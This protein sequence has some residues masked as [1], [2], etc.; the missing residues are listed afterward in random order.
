MLTRRNFVCS[1]AILLFVCAQLP[2]M[3]WAQAKSDAA[4]SKDQ[5]TFEVYQDT[6]KE[7]RWRLVSGEGKDREV[8]ATGGQGYKVKPK[9]PTGKWLPL[10]ARVTKPRRSATA[11]SNRSRKGRPKRQLRKSKPTNRDAVRFQHFRSPKP[12]AENRGVCCAS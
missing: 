4:K 2:A 8:L 9:L 5:L 11:R 12:R 6:A 1:F 10:P 7:F 3:L